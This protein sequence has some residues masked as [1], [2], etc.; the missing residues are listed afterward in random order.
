MMY[1]GM[2]GPL[3]ESVQIRIPH[4]TILSLLACVIELSLSQDVQSYRLLAEYREDFHVLS[5]FTFSQI[6]SHA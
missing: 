6:E 1:G 3:Y 4:M 2:L 5:M